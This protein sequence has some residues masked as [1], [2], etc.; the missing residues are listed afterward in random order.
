MGKK[1][2][3]VI[4]FPAGMVTVEGFEPNADKRLFMFVIFF[5]DKPASGKI[6]F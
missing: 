5:L 1:S 2:M 6:F 4:D 3:S